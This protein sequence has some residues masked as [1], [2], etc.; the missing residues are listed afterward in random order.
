M[1]KKAE[2]ESRRLNRALQ[3][4]SSCNQALVRAASESHLLEEICGI[5]VREGGYRMAWVGVG[6]QDGTKRVSPVAF[7]GFEDGYLESAKVTWA[8]TE[9]GRGPTGTAIRTG[10]TVIT[11]NIQADPN[12]LVWRDETLKRGYASGIALPIVLRGRVFGSL[13]IYAE[14]PD[15]FDSA[16][17]E[18]LT[19]L[20]D[21]LAYG[22]Q[23]IR[24]KADRERAEEVLRQSEARLKEA[25][26]IAHVGSALWDVATDTTVWSEELYRIAG[27]D[28]RQPPP[29]HSERASLYTPESGHASRAP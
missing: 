17:V 28:P 4:L 2:A 14:E 26:R 16:E 8:D 3:T 13:T 29:R 10:Q 18:L 5:L 24:T 22:I 9:R 21:D 25:Q 6:E 7:A 19:E 11:R 23:A 1:R 12:L 15:A 27:R 20:R